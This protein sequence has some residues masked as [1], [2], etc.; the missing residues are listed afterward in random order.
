MRSRPVGCGPAA[1][2]DGD[3]F[4][5]ATTSEPIFKLHAQSV[6]APRST[7]KWWFPLQAK[8]WRP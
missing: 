8:E 6:Q 4:G 2:F 1:D 3:F 7:V 5:W